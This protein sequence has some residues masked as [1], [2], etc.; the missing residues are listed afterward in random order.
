[1]KQIVSWIGIAVMTVALPAL[2]QVQE[3]SPTATSQ[4]SGANDVA[5]LAKSWPTNSNVAAQY[6]IDKYGTPDAA[7]EARLLWNNRGQWSQ[8]TLFRDG[9]SDN[10]PTTHL[11]ILESTIHYDV[12]QDKAGELIKFYPALTVNRVSGTLSVRSDSEAANILA[13]NLAD[14]IVRGKR[15]IDSARDFMRDT[16]RKSQAGKTSPYMDHLLFP[17]AERGPIRG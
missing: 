2:G 1:M 15:D 4:M 17:I 12:P 11:N 13:L 10:F 9:V 6:L 3:S 8:I 16:L 14:E 5:N 7:T